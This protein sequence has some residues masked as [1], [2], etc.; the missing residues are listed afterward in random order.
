M[1][2]LFL[3][4]FV[5]VACTVPMGTSIG[6]A[7]II[8]GLSTGT[9]TGEYIVRTIITSYDS[10]NIIAVALF[11]LA[12]E[13]MGRGGISEKL[14]NLARL[15]VGRFTGGV[16]M[17]VVIACLMFGALAGA[18]A[19]CTAAVGC[20]MIPQMIR[21]GYGRGFSAAIVAAAG[22]LAIIMPP[23]LPFILYSVGSG[24]SIGDQFMAGIV[25][26]VFITL[27]LMFYCWLHCKRH[28][29]TNENIDLTVPG[30]PLEVIKDSF[31]AMLMPLIILGGIY[32]GWF[33]PTEAAAVAVA[34]GLIISMFVYRTLS[35]KELY[36]TLLAAAKSSCTILFILGNA[37]IF[38]RILTLL[39]I[40]QQIT[41]MLLAISDNKVVFLILVNILLIIVGVFMETLSSVMILTPILVPAATALG[42][43]PIHFGVIM[44]VNLAVGFITPPMAINLFIASDIAK[45]KVEELVKHILPTVAVLLVGLLFI[46]YIDWFSLV[47]IK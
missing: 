18:G 29:L 5:L 1:A 9:M 39:E 16:P 46:T 28:G 31:L 44:A 34:Y 22:G 7:S 40:P 42:V 17:A 35:L 27:L 37:T 26:A 36:E 41:E 25:P 43:D 6:L 23:S 11:L 15:A 32:G 14:F 24:T 2:T 3:I 13:I 20:I 47:L 21:M 33:T 38:G 30:K 4:L 8:T 12:G 10:F 45:I 19:A